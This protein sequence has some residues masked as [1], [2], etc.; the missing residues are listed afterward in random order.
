LPLPGLTPT[1]R[2]LLAIFTSTIISLVAQ[3]VPMLIYRLH[4]PSIV[5][6]CSSRAL[7]R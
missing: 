4:P 1:Q 5:A 3:P 7:I 6:A 2:H